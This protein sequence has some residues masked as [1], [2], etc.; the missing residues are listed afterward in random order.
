MITSEGVCNAARGGGGILMIT[1][2]WC[3]N[4]YE[5]RVL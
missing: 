5:R 4:N 3:S 1:K 2:G